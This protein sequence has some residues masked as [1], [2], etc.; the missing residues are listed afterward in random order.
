MPPWGRPPG[1]RTRRARD[2]WYREQRRRWEEQARFE[3]LDTDEDEG[4]VESWDQDVHARQLGSDE[5]YFTGGDLGGRKRPPRQITYK[6]DDETD[7]G[8]T[9]SDERDQEGVQ[10][11][12]R[13]K[14]AQL[15]R[16]A[17]ERI[18]RAQALGKPNVRL[19]KPE[20]EALERERQ[21]AGSKAKGSRP[22]AGSSRGLPDRRPR[23]DRAGPS[24]EAVRSS[25]AAGRIAPKAIYDPE[26]S[27]YLPGVGP[28]GHVD[29]TLD[30]AG[31]Y[32]P[33]EYRPPRRRQSSNSLSRPGSSRSSQPHTPPSPAQHDSRPPTRYFSLPE[34]G[35]PSSRAPAGHSRS[36]SRSTAQAPT[37]YSVD[38]MQYQTHPQSASYAPNARGVS[39]PVST[40]YGSVQRR[41]APSATPHY[42]PYP[43]DDRGAGLASASDPALA[44]RWPVRA[45]PPTD[46]AEPG[47]AEPA[48]PEDL[49][50]NNE[51][52]DV[53]YGPLPPAS[54]PRVRD[55]TAA[56]SPPRYPR[57]RRI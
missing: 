4:S 56:P 46:Q 57:R 11:A 1:G 54:S 30:H 16:T 8:E 15:A 32:P 50:D 20:Y 43:D 53:A 24:R 51:D 44:R 14:E 23:D 5:L 41:P 13:D 3:E 28:T 33:L 39:D 40:Q 25:A 47:L 35:L 34:S 22:Q 42:L 52:Y 6:E 48:S 21:R 7:S 19:S 18:R 12:L 2:E 38:P 49:D 17:M 10:V 36:R 37:Q 26:N 27:P 55:S 31:P 29:Y 9:N 45:P